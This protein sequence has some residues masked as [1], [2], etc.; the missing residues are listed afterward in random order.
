MKWLKLSKK[1]LKINKKIK[2]LGVSVPT[3]LT[4]KSLKELGYKKSIKDIV[5]QAL[6]AK[7]AKLDG[8]IV[9]QMRQNFWNRYAIVWK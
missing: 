5:K 8:V 7:K 9:Q 1:R 4:N 3:S 2:I 6:L